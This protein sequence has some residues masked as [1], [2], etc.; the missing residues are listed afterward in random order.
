MYKYINTYKAKAVLCFCLILI[1]G[2]LR[3]QNTSHYKYTI[4]P[5]DTCQAIIADVLEANNHYYLLTGLY[6]SEPF[7]VTT[8][9]VAVYDEDLHPIEQI[10][11]SEIDSAFYPRRFFYKDNYFYVFGY[12][13]DSSSSHIDKFYYAKYD[14]NFRL[15][16]PVISYTLQDTIFRLIDTVVRNNDTTIHD[17][18]VGGAGYML[19]DIFMTHSDEFIVHFNLMGSPGNARR[20]RLFHFDTTGRVLHD[21]FVPAF[22]VSGT[23]V[24]TD[25]HY[26]MNYFFART[27]IRLY[28]K[29]SFENYQEIELEDN[30]RDRKSTRLNSSH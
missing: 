18:M 12:V 27:Y 5:V 3:A 28:P 13:Y 11:L 25:S 20:G 21:M 30:L 15:A 17:Y 6:N 23:M 9:F 22:L 4:A 1:A 19:A 16:Q 26:I 7:I 2:S 24:E 14:T 10:S 8:P 29:N